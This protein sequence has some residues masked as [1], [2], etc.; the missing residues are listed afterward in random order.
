MAGRR[1]GSA[2][3]SSFTSSVERA[4]MG[5]FPRTPALATCAAKFRSLAK[6]SSGVCGVV[7]FLKSGSAKLRRQAS[8]SS[9]ESDQNLPGQPTATHSCKRIRFAEEMAREKSRE[10]SK[11]RASHVRL[12]FANLPPSGQL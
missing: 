9:R 2:V 12:S 3:A 1:K 8:S 5:V 4:S 10:A 11:R 6:V 7:P